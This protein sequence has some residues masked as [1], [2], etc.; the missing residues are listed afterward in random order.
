MKSMRKICLI[1]ARS[2]SKGL[3]NKNMLFLEGKPMLFYTIEAA[4]SSGCFEKED[5]YV[6]TDSELY[7][8]ICETTG[9]KVLLRPAALSTDFTPSNEVSTHFLN[10]L[11][12]SEDCIFVLLQVTSP[13]RTGAHIQEAMELFLQGEAENVVSFVQAEKTPKFMTTVDANGYAKDICGVDTGYRRQNDPNKFYVPNGAIYITTRNAYVKNQSHFTPRTK[14]YVMKKEDSID[15]DDRID[16]T[17]IE[18]SLYFDYVRQEQKQKAKHQE[19]YKTLSAQRK[20]A[21]LLLCDD[22]LAGVS[23]QGFENWSL[24]GLTLSTLLENIEYVLAK[25]TEQVIVSLGIYDLR[26]GYGLETIKQNLEKILNV[27]QKRVKKVV[28]TTLGH[29]LFRDHLSN[30]DISSLNQW[31]FEK[32]KVSPFVLVDLDKALVENGHLKYAYTTDGLHWN[33]EGKAYVIKQLQ[34]ACLA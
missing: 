20:Q 24:E 30:E 13:L 32:A 28:L 26:L 6:S 16:F 27:L 1:P 9:V 12:F 7:K 8:E 25:E 21:S 29:T 19:A 15:V 2:G 23:L 10:H 14:A 3:P 34:E 18:G 11:D 33:E 5:I 31:L 17:C 4:L 22:R